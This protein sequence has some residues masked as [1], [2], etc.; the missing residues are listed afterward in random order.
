MKNT[1][2]QSDCFLWFELH[3]PPITSN[4]CHRIFIR[5][6]NFDII[7][8]EIINPCDFKVPRAKVK[9]ALSHGKKFESRACELNID[10]VRLKLRH[11]VLVRKTGLVIQPSLLWLAAS[12]DRLV[13]Y[14]T[15]DIKLLLE[16]KCP[17][18]ELHVTY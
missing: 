4:I 13:A 14:Q 16:V 17:Q 7:C 1:R 10:M 2:N 3:K 11:F 6:R 15:S 18:K 12:P 5:Q 9:E 8:T